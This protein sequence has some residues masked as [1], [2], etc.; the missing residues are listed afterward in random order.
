MGLRCSVL[1]HRYGERERI[2][3]R[4]EQGTEIVHISR[5]VKTCERCGDTLLITENKEITHAHTPEQTAPP[6]EPVLDDAPPEPN[7]TE[8]ADTTEEEDDGL[9]LP[10]EPTDREPGD[11]P[12]DPAPD[13][14]E[15]PADAESMWPDAPTDDVEAENS[16]EADQ[17]PADWPEVSGEDEGY[18][19]VAGDIADDAETEVIEA[20]Q[21]AESSDIEITEAGFARA[22]PIDS[23]EDPTNNEIRT[24]YYCPQCDWSDMSLVASVRRGDICPSCKKGYVAERKLS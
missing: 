15:L 17:A 23:T 16:A 8:E 21:P 9:I 22:R 13:D 24:E 10:N 12:A 20:V 11:W 7:I 3:E 6:E 2:E 5:E 1:G 19:A 4:D 14:E 18:D